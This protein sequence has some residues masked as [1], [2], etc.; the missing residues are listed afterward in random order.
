MWLQRGRAL[1]LGSGIPSMQPWRG[2]AESGASL[3]SLVLSRL[4]VRLNTINRLGPHLL[5][6]LTPTLTES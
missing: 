4:P 6:S 2:T 3:P 1:P 5:R